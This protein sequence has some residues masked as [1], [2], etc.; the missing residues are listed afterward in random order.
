MLYI[1]V[2]KMPLLRFN[3]INVFTINK[4]KRMGLN[5]YNFFLE[6]KC[7]FFRYQKSW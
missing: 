6:K 4:K 2:Y 1:Y 3:I 7:R 5:F